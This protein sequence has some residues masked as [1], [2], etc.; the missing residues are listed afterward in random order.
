MIIS[1]IL[2]KNDYSLLYEMDNDRK[3]D[4]DLGSINSFILNSYAPINNHELRPHLD[5]KCNYYK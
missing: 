1:E 3:I 2:T 4:S 5:G